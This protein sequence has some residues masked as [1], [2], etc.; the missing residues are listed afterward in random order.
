MLLMAS[1]IFPIF[2]AYNPGLGCVPLVVIL[3]ITALKDAIEDYRRTVL[4]NELNNSPVHRLVDWTNVNVTEDNISLWRR[5]KKATSRG[6]KWC[7]VRM[8]TLRGKNTKAS[9][10]GK[11]Y[12][13]N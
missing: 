1:Q 3:F 8:K 4:D 11:G 6:I 9:A 13:G 5:I 10:K 12:A 7:Y 2:G